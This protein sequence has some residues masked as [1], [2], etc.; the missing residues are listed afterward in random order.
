MI[1]YPKLIIKNDR[2]YFVDN[3]GCLSKDNFTSASLY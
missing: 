2:F 1:N 3:R